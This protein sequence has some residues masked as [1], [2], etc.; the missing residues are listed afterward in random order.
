M[1][2]LVALV[3][4]PLLAAGCNKDK[5]DASKATGPLSGV[6]AVTADQNGFAPSA[7]RL[8]HGEPAT[9][10]FTRTTDE[11]CAD[12]VVFPELKIEKDLPRDQAVDIPI[13]TKEKKTLAFQC[14]MGMY[15]SSVTI[16]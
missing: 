12:K 11:T 15:K 2:L 16:E 3:A 7:I 5:P 1:R 14:G 6:V 8:K 9:L 13:D 10:R 4:L